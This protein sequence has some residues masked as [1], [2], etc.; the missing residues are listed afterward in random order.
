MWFLMRF[1]EQM[2]PR[3][4][5]MENVT[6]MSGWA[7]FDELMDRLR[8]DYFVSIQRLDASEFGVPQSRKRLF[9]L[10]DR[11]RPTKSWVVPAVSGQRATSSIL[12]RPGLRTISTPTVGRCGRSSAPKL[13]QGTRQGRGFP[14]RLLRFRPRRRLA[15]A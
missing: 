8:E 5:I 7:G 15:D 1:I 14:G 4:V 6:T 3:W 12:W 2:K 9:I 11:E 10:C 13:D